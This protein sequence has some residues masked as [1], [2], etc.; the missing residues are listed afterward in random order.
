MRI[1]VFDSGL[2]GLTV[3]RSLMR[4][5]PEVD[6]VYLADTAWAPYGEK[7]HDRIR[8]RSEEIARYLLMR[9]R[10]DGLV[11][12][13]NTATSAAINHLRKLFSDLPIV[14]TEPG[15]KPAFE[16]TRTHHVGILATPATLAGD[17]YQILSDRLYRHSDVVLHEQ[18]C[19]GLVEQ[20]EAG[21]IDAPETEA[22]LTRW[23]TPMREAGVD[24]IVLG[25]THYPLAGDAIRRIMGAEVTLIETGDAIARRLRDLIVDALQPKKDL[26]Q[27]SLL[28]TGALDRDAV[29]RILGRSMDVQTID[30]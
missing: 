1:G 26:S 19:P 9:Y 12:A 7:H 27:T 22:M 25:C 8:H 16:R 21:R 15:I 17:K 6:Y 20:I 5:I 24:T 30:L 10:I 11:V 23:L 28:T 14:G 13:C 18:A 29:E 2:G 4:H 3:L